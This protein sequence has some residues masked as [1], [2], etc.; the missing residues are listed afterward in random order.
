MRRTVQWAMAVVLFAM[1]ALAIAGMELT[2][3]PNGSSFSAAG[4]T[5][6]SGTNS[7]VDQRPLTQAQ[8]LA[9][10]ASTPQEQSL[11]NEAVQL[12]DHEVDLAF[13]AALRDAA[14]K[15]AASTPKALQLEQR[16]KQAQAQVDTEQATVNSLTERVKG[17][18][19][20]QQANLQSQLELAQAELAL[21]RDELGDAQRDLVREG[22]N[23]EAELQ[24]MLDEHEKATAPAETP[25]SAAA[26]T[27]APTAVSQPRKAR[28][29]VA[30]LS[31][32]TGVANKQKRIEQARTDALNLAA[33]LDR[34]HALLQQ[35]IQTAQARQA[36]RGKVAS[37][38]AQPG[39][40]ASELS[41][42]R[43]L[44]LYQ[45]D[46]SDYDQ[47][48][49]TEQELADVYGQWAA[50]AAASTQA[51]LHKL[52]RALFW[53]L[54]LLLLAV[55]ADLL[56]SHLFQGLSLDRK[57]LHTIQSVLHFTTRGIATILIL[58]V[59][60]GPPQQLATVLGLAG[61]G[62]AVALKDFIVAFLGWFV[63]MGPH[64]MR[65]GDWVE[66][67]GA[68]QINGV[69]GKVLEVGLLFTV[70][71]ETGNWTDA[72]HPTGRR[73]AFMNSFAIEGYYFNFTTAGQWLWDE[74]QVGLPPGIN[75]YP[76]LET[77][78]KVA[79]RETEKNVKLAEQE[80]QRTMA[81]SGL[82]SFSAAPVIVVR[83]TEAGLNVAVR[84]IASADE[85]EELRMRLFRAAFEILHGVKELA[86]EA[87]APASTK[88]I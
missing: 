1:V 60:F 80:W 56:I 86:P 23:Q 50:L 58:I 39:A 83:P 55:L 54:L 37:A 8:R 3:S 33:S 29:L 66:I 35:T 32:W 41:S 7:P 47:R 57:R 70:I 53:V 19:G 43:Q 45:Q 88:P 6:P 82:E 59:I 18:R 74:V 27:S 31:A 61:A 25:A 20:V 69:Q 30:R 15:P 67:N 87:V 81:R 38:G 48:I 77:L 22:G 73:V 49:E 84:Y 62:L 65:P 68:Q 24:Q 40:T 16:V 72:G 5:G 44:S 63:L 2:R 71:L 64:G 79:E 75:P 26:A 76:L 13:A 17:A 9:T 51:A 4:R 12:A 46:L 52:I 14:A 36:A 42:V 34:A 85:R 21:D 10:L 11:S 28:G 78:Q